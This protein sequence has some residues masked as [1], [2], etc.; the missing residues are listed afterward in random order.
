MTNARLEGAFKVV[1]KNVRSKLVAVIKSCPL[2][3]RS[4]HK[5]GGRAA[6]RNLAA[7]DRH[8]RRTIS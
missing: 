1:T 5:V 8:L 7:S 2:I 4:V 3:N 6:R